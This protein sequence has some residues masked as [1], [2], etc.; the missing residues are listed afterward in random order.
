MM[1]VDQSEDE[2]RKE[3]VARLIAAG[4]TRKEA[5]AEYERATADLDTGVSEDHP[6]DIPP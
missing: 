2:N 4:W 6:G 3:F 5:L 1:S